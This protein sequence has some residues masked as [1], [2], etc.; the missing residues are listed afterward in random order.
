MYKNGHRY[1]QKRIDSPEINP[2]IYSQLDFEKG[3]KNLQ[4]ENDSL[5]RLKIT[6][7]F[8]H[9]FFIDTLSIYPL[10]KYLK[11]K[12]TKIMKEKN[13]IPIIFKS[14]EISKIKTAIIATTQ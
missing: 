12:G 9:I 6:V 2:N 10:F 4:W 13:K 3:A 8:S 7:I 11:I 14:L 5:G 1:Q